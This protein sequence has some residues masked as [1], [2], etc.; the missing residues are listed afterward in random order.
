[1]LVLL[2]NS[3]PLSEW[4][5][6]MTKGNCWR[7]LSRSGISQAP[8]MRGVASNTPPLCELIDGVDVVDPLA[9]GRVALVHTVDAQKAGLAVGCGLFAFA[10]LDRSGPGLF[11]VEQA[12]TVT[13][14]LAQVV[15]VAVGQSCQP[16]ELRLAIDLEFALENMP[17][18]RAAEPL[19][20]LVNRG[21]Q[22]HIGHSVMALEAGSRR[23]LGAIR[24]MRR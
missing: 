24:P 8:E 14:T 20:R 12:Q 16:L 3:L 9:L 2:M 23:G 19:V 11:I 13:P 18:G 10:D 6:R 15:E 21:Q 1:M 4:K 7:M 17:R 5:L 22:F